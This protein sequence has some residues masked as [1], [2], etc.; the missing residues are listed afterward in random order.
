MHVD[1]AL[2]RHIARLARLEIT[3]EEAASLERELSTIF[4]WVEQLKEVDV[5]DVQPLTRIAAMRMKMREDKVTDGG[6]P[7]GILKNAPMSEDHFFMVPKV[8]E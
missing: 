8:L 7:D 6:Y 1:E 5:S 2:V 3:N 4:D